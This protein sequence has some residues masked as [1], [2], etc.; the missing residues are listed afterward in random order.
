MVGSIRALEATDTVYWRSKRSGRRN[1]FL[2]MLVT[3][4]VADITS[5]SADFLCV[6]LAVGSVGTI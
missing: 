3:R 6:L 1:E 2:L 4:L 5:V